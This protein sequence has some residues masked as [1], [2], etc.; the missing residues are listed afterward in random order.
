MSGATI[1][2]V[3]AAAPEA[4]TSGPALVALGGSAGSLEAVRTILAGLPVE[5]EAAVVVVQHRARESDALAE[6]LQISSPLPVVE[7][8]DKDPVEAGRVYIAPADYHLL[9]E[10]GHFALSTDEPV[11]FSRPSIDVLFESAADAY[12]PRALGVV[13]T[14][15]NRDGA[16]GLRRIVDRGG[17]A[18]VQDPA[19]AEAATMPRAALEAVP[20]GRT[21]PLNELGAAIT[22]WC[23]NRHALCPQETA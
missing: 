15:A 1:V 22:A 8:E 9:L 3:G 21:V 13:L 16:Q 14:G 23:Q 7:A 11:L 12:G 4:R 10:P 17:A 20:E 6:V 18:L 2:A 5:L 19:T